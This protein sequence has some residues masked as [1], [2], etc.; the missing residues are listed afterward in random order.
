MVNKDKRN[1]I[2]A[3]VFFTAIIVAFNLAI[4]FLVF[5]SSSLK[6]AYDNG[7]EVDLYSKSEYSYSY[8]GENSLPTIKTNTEL[9]EHPYSDGY[10]ILTSDDDSVV[11]IANSDNISD[12]IKSNISDDTDNISEYI[13]TLPEL[14]DSSSS[15]MRSLFND[16]WYAETLDDNSIL[17]SSVDGETSGLINSLYGSDVSKSEESILLSSNGDIIM[18]A[19]DNDSLITEI[20]SGYES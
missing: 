7:E 18:I 20:V 1:T 11:I 16:G 15:L 4:V 12:K 8:G 9:T 6:S 5:G 14:P 2:I 17:L 19:T 13:K 10:Q 3:G